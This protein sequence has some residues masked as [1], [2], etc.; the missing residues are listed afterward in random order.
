MNMF[1][2]PKYTVNRNPLS[3]WI[4]WKARKNMR[5]TRQTGGLKPPRGP[6]TRGAQAVR[7]VRRTQPELDLLKVNTSF[8]PPDHS[9]QPRDCYRIIGEGEAPLGD[10]MRTNF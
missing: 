7:V 4:E 6:S 8:P 5:R 9:N 1:G 10:A 2:V 3:K